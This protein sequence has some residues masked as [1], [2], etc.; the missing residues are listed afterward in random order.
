M[1]NKTILISNDSSENTLTNFNQVDV[2]PYDNFDRQSSTFKRNKAYTRMNDYEISF[3]PFLSASSHL[4]KYTLDILESSEDL[5]ADEVRNELIAKINLFDENA[6]KLGIENTEMLVTR[7]ILCTVVDEFMNSSSLGLNNNWSNNSVLRIFHKETYGG[8]NFFHLLDK[9]LKT[10]AKY[11]HIL[12]LM[13]I[14]IALGFEGKYRVINRGQIELNNVKDSLFR[15]IK[16]VQGRDPFPFFIK[17]EASKNKFRLFNKISYPILFLGV[18]LLVFSVYGILT[19]TLN[20]HN[21]KFI[22]MIENK[23]IEKNSLE[24]EK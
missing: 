2:S 5:N 20:E 1:S 7:Y 8:E 3:N 21:S 12:E 4:F 16:I 18:L 9:F 23:K 22:E 10:P 19:F 6:L 13:Y 11:I 24:V 15:Q 14:C 17:Q